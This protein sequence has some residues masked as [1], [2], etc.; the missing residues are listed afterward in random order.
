FEARLQTDVGGLSADGERG[1]DDA[2]DELV[3]V[4]PDERPVLERARLALGR[5][6]DDEASGA[7]LPGDARPLAA[8]GEPSPA[9]APE[10]RRGDDVDRGLRPHPLRGV[11]PEPADVGG[12]PVV[13]RA[14]RLGRKEEGAGHGGLLG[15]S[16]HGLGFALPRVAPGPASAEARGGPGERDGGPARQRA[17]SGRRRRQ[18]WVTAGDCQPPSAGLRLVPG[19]T[20][21][22]MRSSVASSST[23][24]P[25]SRSPSSCSIV[26]GPM[27]AE[28]TAGWASTNPSARWGRLSPASP[29]SCSS[30]GMRSSLR[31]TPA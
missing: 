2:L 7:L 31:R 26:R 12:Q 4:G 28:V 11:D 3:G 9:T 14:D 22:S 20:I 19:G 23:T 27:I 24:S 1:D 13:E 21:S 18:A 5:V 8:G 16:T 25:A 10:A 29:A 30:A 15:S 17:P 6:A